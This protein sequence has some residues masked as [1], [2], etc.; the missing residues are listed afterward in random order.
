[1]RSDYRRI[2]LSI[3]ARYDPKDNVTFTVS[4]W[5]ADN[6]AGWG[7]RASYDA[8]DGRSREGN[9]A[10]P[11]Q[12]KEE[13]ETI[14]EAIRRARQAA[15]PVSA[16]A[17]AVGVTPGVTIQTRTP[18][19]VMQCHSCGRLW[20]GVGRQE[21]YKESILCS[22]GKCYLIGRAVFTIPETEKPTS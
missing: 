8:E 16:P 4:R 7:V 12:S 13:A 9:L 1:V 20:V 14:V 2:A 6:E 15:L 10:Y 18:L 11:A 22:C 3:I 17:N 5:A 21:D 19:W